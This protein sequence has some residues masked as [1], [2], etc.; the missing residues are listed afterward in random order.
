MDR[1]RVGWHVGRGQARVEK[2]NEFLEVEAD[3]LERFRAGNQST[4]QGDLI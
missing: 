1:P 4:R 2:C 3:G